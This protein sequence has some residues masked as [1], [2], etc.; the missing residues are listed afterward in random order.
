MPLWTASAA[1]PAFLLALKQR[2]A[3]MRR[4]GYLHFHIGDRGM[5]PVWWPARCTASPDELA[6][7]QADLDRLV[8]ADAE[9]ALPRLAAIVATAPWQLGRALAEAAALV[10]DGLPDSLSVGRALALIRNADGVRARAEIALRRLRPE[11]WL[12]LAESADVRAAALE[13]CRLL[14]ALDE[15]RA[16]RRNDAGWGQDDT[17][18]GHLLAEREEISREETA[19]AARLLHHHRRQLP[20]ELR[21]RL[22]DTVPG[23][24]TAPVL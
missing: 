10:R 9:A 2:P 18:I 23:P 16:S 24:A 15:D 11:G 17:S 3:D 20:A 6:A 1:T 22:F 13:G 8:G 7:L 4:A 19:H 5:R 14:S 12:R 21:S